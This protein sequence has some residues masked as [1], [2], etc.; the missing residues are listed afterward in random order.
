MGVVISDI[1]I[2]VNEVNIEVGSIMTSGEL[3]GS[4]GIVISIII[5]ELSSLAILSTTFGDH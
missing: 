5:L 2:L 3:G 4:I 1:E